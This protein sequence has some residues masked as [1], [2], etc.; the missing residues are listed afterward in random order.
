MIRGSKL[1]A[2]LCCRALL[3]QLRIH[4]RYTLFPH[5][6]DFRRLG[7]AGHASR[8]V[9]AGVYRRVDDRRVVDHRVGY[10]AVVHLNVVYVHVVHR[11]VVIEAISPPVSA[12]VARAFVAVSII[13]AAVVADM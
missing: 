4:R 5:C 1:L 12:L 13:D 6:C 8:S 11:A 10:S 7:A 9:V 3:L 2:V